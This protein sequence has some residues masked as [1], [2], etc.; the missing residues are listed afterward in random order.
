[1][2]DWIKEHP[3]LT[4]TFAVGVI[5]LYIVYRNST[6][7]SAGSVIQSNGPSDVAI[8]AGSALQYAQ[9]QSQTQIAG[10]NAALNAQALNNA[11]D[12]EKTRLAANVALQNTLSTADVAKYTVDA[13]LKLGLAQVG[14]Q[15][16]YASNP[17]PT[18]TSVYGRTDQVADAKATADA[19]GTQ[20]TQAVTDLSQR[21]YAVV[22][23]P[24]GGQGV[25]GVEEQ[26]CS[27]WDQ[28]TAS[29][30]GANQG[31]VNDS[32]DKHPG[33][34]LGNGIYAGT[35]E[36]WAIFGDPRVTWA[37]HLKGDDNPYA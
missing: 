26:T 27:F 2:L 28:L 14:Q 18:T 31:A 19:R 20:I 22:V 11:A 35:P 25:H 23:G 9:M 1:M 12:V 5:L 8:Q 13:Q 4:G 16:P 30:A 34:Y 24:G 15:T 17:V 10:Y 32:Y 7:S 21:G 29:C 36:A 33:S 6:S 3:Y 37:D